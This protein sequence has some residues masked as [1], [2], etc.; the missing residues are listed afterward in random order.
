MQVGQEDRR[1]AGQAVG[2]DGALA[3][4]QVQGRLNQGG[5]EGLAAAGAGFIRL[6]DCQQLSGQL[7]QLG[8][9]QAAVPLAAGL[10]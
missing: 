6:L 3:E 7:E 4:L 5:F 8:G 1:L 10:K 9:G 2:H